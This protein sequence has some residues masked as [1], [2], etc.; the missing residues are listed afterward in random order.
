LADRL[1]G[2]LATAAA[3]MV[4]GAS[5]IRVHDVVATVQLARLYGPAA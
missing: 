4:A 1:E 5:M 3:A 2:S